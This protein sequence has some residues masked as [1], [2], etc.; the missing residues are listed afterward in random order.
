ML[1][2]RTAYSVFGVMR[3]MLIGEYKD[4]LTDLIRATK[5][6]NRAFLLDQLKPM[7]RHNELSHSQCRCEQREARLRG[8]VCVNPEST[9]REVKTWLAQF[10]CAEKFQANLRRGKRGAPRGRHSSDLLVCRYLGRQQGCVN[11][12]LHGKPASENLEL[13]VHM[14][15]FIGALTRKYQA[16][17]FDTHQLTIPT[18]VK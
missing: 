7:R 1:R 15:Y 13:V 2:K 14:K 5:C 8:R 3:R 9:N 6:A 18:F 10:L 17:C 12:M 4:C 11:T 16:M